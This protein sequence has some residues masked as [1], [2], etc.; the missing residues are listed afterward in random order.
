[1][2]P[3]QVIVGPAQRLVGGQTQGAGG[4]PADL[5]GNHLGG[6][7]ANVFG[8]GENN[9]AQCKRLQR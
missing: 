6:S 4:G 9:D 8:G 5:P 3:G 1:M 7:K 2:H